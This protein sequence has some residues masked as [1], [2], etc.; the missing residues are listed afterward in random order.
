MWQE[1]CTGFRCRRRHRRTFRSIFAHPN[2]ADG[3]LS[4]HAICA[5]NIYQFVKCILKCKSRCKF[6]FG[7]STTFFKACLFLLI[8]FT[9]RKCEFVFMEL[10]FATPWMPLLQRSMKTNPED[11]QT[12]NKCLAMNGNYMALWMESPRNLNSESQFR[13][14]NPSCFSHWLSL[15]EKLPGS[16]KI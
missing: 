3:L 6:V 8:L 2:Y 5:Y 12:R 9:S 7:Y 10:F 13:I 15:G 11:E 14:T 16:L 4:S 1:R